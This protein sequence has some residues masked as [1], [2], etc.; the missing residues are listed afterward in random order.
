MLLD[1]A[2]PLT[3]YSR[4]SRGILIL[5]QP[6]QLAVSSDFAWQCI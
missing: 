5:L 6:G 2:S 1:P 3:R 4:L